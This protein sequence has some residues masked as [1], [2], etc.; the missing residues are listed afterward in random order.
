M[1]LEDTH[2]KCVYAGTTA[3]GANYFSRYKHDRSSYVSLQRHTIW[4]IPCSLAREAQF[5]A[6]GDN[7]LGC[8]QLAK[9]YFPFPLTTVVEAT[10]ESET[11]VMESG[12]EVS[13]VFANG[14]FCVP[15]SV[16]FGKECCK[17]E[18]HNEIVQQVINNA[19]NKLAG[20]MKAGTPKKKKKTAKKPPTEA[21]SASTTAKKKKTKAASASS[22]G[23]TT[24]G[25]SG[26]P[27]RGATNDTQSRKRKAGPEKER[28]RSSRRKNT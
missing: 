26:K 5:R 25:E 20:T 3:P 6:V 14:N 11:F 13:K 22:G 12:C 17:Y 8:D 16:T 23:S 9:S 2:S 24:R 28:K 21:A 27:P 15:V 7:T 1:Q 18:R 19:K 4:N 10:Y